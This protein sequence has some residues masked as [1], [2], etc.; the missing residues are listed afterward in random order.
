MASAQREPTMPKLGP[1]NSG[2]EPHLREITNH[3]LTYLVT[4]LKEHL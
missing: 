2:S 4:Y 3:L 1:L